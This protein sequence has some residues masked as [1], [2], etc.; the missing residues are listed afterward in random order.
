MID[1]LIELMISQ[2]GYTET[3]NNN[4]KYSKFFDTTAWQF[5]NTKKQG[6]DWC[7]IFLLYCWYQLL[8]AAG[9][10][11]AFGLPTDPKD[12]CA[13]G[14]KFLYNY[15]K[16]KGMLIKKPQ[17]GCVVFFNNLG[18]V[19]TCE[20]VDDKLHTIEGNKSNKVKRCSYTLTSSKIYA[21]AM[22]KLPESST[23]PAPIDEPKQ[24]KTDYA[25]SFNRLFNKT[26]ITRVE[27]PLMTG[28]NKKTI[29]TIPAGKSVRCYGYFTG[30]YLY[31]TY[32]KYEG[33]V[34][35]VF[36]R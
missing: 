29:L 4:T 28:A 26:Y 31:V 35:R 8:G 5:F 1:K 10:R 36:L 22:P 14:V 2:L 34:R 23:A 20:Y 17:K 3:G 24:L 33:F 30:D 27:C 6:A 21:Y 15:M 19:G 32:G 11:K 7:P 16:A 25:A 13:A 18:H 12:N 9:T